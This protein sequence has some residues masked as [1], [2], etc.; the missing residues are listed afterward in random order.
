MDLCRGG[1][2]T[3]IMRSDFTLQNSMA[4]P[5]LESPSAMTASTSSSATHASGAAAQGLGSNMGAVGA[6][7]AAL[8]F[9]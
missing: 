3:R 9:L 6:A 5:H 2:V 4:N 1:W 7:V 8:A